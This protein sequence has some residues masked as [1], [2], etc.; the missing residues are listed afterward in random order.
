[1]FLKHKTTRRYKNG[2]S[3]VI[4][5]SRKLSQIAFYNEHGDCIN[6]FYCANSRVNE[7]IGNWA[8][9]NGLVLVESEEEVV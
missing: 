5:K 3:V 2:Y 7:E 4:V 6:A 9:F 1:M 8:D